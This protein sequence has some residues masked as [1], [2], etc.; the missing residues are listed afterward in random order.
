MISRSRALSFLFDARVLLPAVALAT[1]AGCNKA[2]LLAPTNS[3]ISLTAAN[4]VLPTGGTTQLTAVVLENS[5]QP[6]P[7]GTTVR[8]TTTLGRVDPIEAETNNGIATAVF[9][10]GSQSGTAEIRAISGLASG[11]T[12]TTTTPGTG[13]GTT[14]TAGGAN[15]V[16]ITIGA[17]AVRGISL[18]ADPGTLRPSGSSVQ[19]SAF[20][21]DA[22]GNPVSGVPVN[23]TTSR[24]TITPAV[25]NT[26][27]NGIATT[28]LSASETA[29]VTAR[30]GGGGTGGGTTTPGAPA[31]GGGSV[32][33]T[34][35]IR[36]TVT[37]SF[38][39]ATS[40]AS[41]SAGQ[42][43]ALTITPAANTA[44]R[45]TVDWGDGTPP[46]DIGAVAAPRSVTHI[47]TLPGFYTINASGSQD[48]DLFTNATAVTVA[49]QPPVQLT[50]N[51]TTAGV[52]VPF[53]FTITPT[54]GALISNITIDYGDGQRDE[55][56]AISTQTTRQHPYQ[57][58]G[59]KVVT[60]TQ[61]ETNG[62]VTT[63]TVTVTVTS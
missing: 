50:V 9:V 34:L 14:T 57:S 41:P 27:G 47:Y 43:V 33:A 54:T 52:G 19:V 49:Q 62:N 20:V 28:T 21:N 15:V 30:A 5:G 12:G 55:L 25:V 36:T 32:T 17:A 18:S 56:G 1:L 13:G 6:V 61:R 8:F 38:T 40:P 31:A 10:A 53:T 23:F 60:V 24:G 2:A 42:P 59:A 16:Q 37:P 7:N 29:T 48:G 46:Q 44:P 39:L 45:V 4:R 26:D 22:D 3:T 63:A 58:P 35:E 11:G 51:P